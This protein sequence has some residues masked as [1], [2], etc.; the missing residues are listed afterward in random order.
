MTE[1]TVLQEEADQFKREYAAV[2]AE[3]G[4]LIVYKDDQKMKEFPLTSPVEVDKAGWWTLF[5][6]TAAGMFFVD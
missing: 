4:K 5:K 1:S 3:I 6:R 2:R